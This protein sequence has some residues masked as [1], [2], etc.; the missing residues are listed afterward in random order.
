MKRIRNITVENIIGGRASYAPTDE[1]HKKIL[2]C[3][4]VG[5]VIHGSMGIA[6]DGEEMISAG[7]MCVFIAPAG[8]LQKLMHVPGED[9]IFKAH[10]AFLD[11]MVDGAPM[12]DVLTLP[13]VL[14]RASSGQIYA[15]IRAMCEETILSRRYIAAYRMLDTLM[16]H[17]TAHEPEE[18]TRTAIRRFVKANFDRR[19]G[20]DE[21]AAA[22]GCS[23]PQV[24]RYTNRYF[25]MSPANYVN[26]VR[27]SHAAWQLEQTDAP[28]RSIALSVGFEDMPYFTKLFKKTFL[29][30]PGEYRERRLRMDN[31][32]V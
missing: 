21:I 30:P 24:F 10:W 7:E 22:L 31:G 4:T 25:G 19:I 27:L 6:L 12:G 14:P 1:I 18:E 8:K 20:A 23:A 2:P 3:L 26:H 13:T 29:L 28:V 32:R 17:A 5:Q 16:A 15:A 11:V 9:G